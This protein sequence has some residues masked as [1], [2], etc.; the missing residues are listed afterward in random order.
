MDR[1]EKM[2]KRL[3]PKAFL[4]DSPHKIYENDAWFSKK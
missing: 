2:D 3:W 1:L 4:I